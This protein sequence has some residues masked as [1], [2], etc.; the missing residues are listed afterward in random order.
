MAGD[1]FMAALIDCGLDFSRLLNELEKLPLNNFR[2]EL[3][4]VKRGALRACH[5][6][7]HVKRA[8]GHETHEGRHEHHQSQGHVHGRSYVEIRELIQTAHF[9]AAVEQRALAIF[10]EIARAESR[11]HGMSLNDVHFHEVGA[12]D[13]IVDI[14]AAAIGIEL[15][16]VS[17]ITCS[18]VGIGCGTR[19]MAH[20]EV[21][22][23]APATAEIIHGMPVCRTKVQDEL[24]TPTGAAIL[25]VLVGQFQPRDAVVFEATGYGAGSADRADPPNVVRV[26]RFRVV[27]E[28]PSVPADELVAVLETQVD[29]C[30]GEVMGNARE[31]LE[32]AGALDVL[33]QSVHMKKNRPGFL[34]T[35]IAT[36]DSA[37]SLQ[38]I[39]LSATSSFG[40]RRHDCRRRV[41]DREIV[42]V[43]TP[44]GGARIKLGLLHGQV[45]QI[46]PEYVDCARLAKASGLALSEVMRIVEDSFTRF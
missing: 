30:T 23:P 19:R 39:M 33:I 6:T 27:D 15:L 21:P 25:K 38:D 41:L 43:E 14:C 3:E 24:L 37:D 36:F 29:D 7:V 22:I 31:L 12:V 11:V 16:G 17:T 8:D 13:S 45:K 4:E 26:Q 1:M 20:G 18:A 44:L 40:V 42:T 9:S 32:T 35:V 28:T 5:A 46:S 34:L 10:E 2:I